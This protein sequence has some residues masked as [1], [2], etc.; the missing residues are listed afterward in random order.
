M[1]SVLSM[2]GIAQILQRAYRLIKA[3]GDLLPFSLRA[4][5]P[6]TLSNAAALTEDFHR[7]RIPPRGRFITLLRSFYYEHFGAEDCCSAQL[8]DAD[9]QALRR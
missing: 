7:R 3:I 9:V 2:S 1:E 6:N 5:N 8:P 4:R